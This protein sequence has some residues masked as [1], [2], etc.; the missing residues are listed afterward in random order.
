MLDRDDASLR[1]AAEDFGHLVHHLPRAVLRPSTIAEVA[2]IVASASEARL[3]VAARGAGHSSYGQAQCAGGIVIDMS[4]L[5]LVSEP[6]VD[7][8][9]VQGG[10]LWSS[11]LEATLAGGTTPAV[12]TDYLHTSVGGT[13]AAGGV[14]GTSH[15]Y[16]FQVD[17]VEE[18]RVVTGT[19]R[20]VTCSPRRN[21]EL[22]DAIRAGLGQCGITVSATLRV[23]PAPALV[24][25]YRL[26]Y[27]DLATF[28]ADQRDLVLQGR[29]DFLQGQI[30]LVAGGWRYLVEAAAYHPPLAVPTGAALPDGLHDDR[31]A[32]EID[33]LPYR[34]FAHR[35]AT[36][37][38]ALRASG[39]WLHPHPWLTTFLPAQDAAALAGEVLASR[40]L[41][42][43][44]NSGLV[45]TY[46]LRADR[47]CAPLTRVPD[48]ELVWLFGLLRTASPED[49]AGVTAQ[50]EA[51]R[52]IR[53]RVLA[54]GGT[55]Y[56]INAVPMSPRDWR[57]HFG[58][59]WEQLR[60]AKEKF[61]PR[62]ILTPGCGISA[63]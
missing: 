36:G 18:L 54:R 10:A 2:D 55:A 49:P 20:P 3:S 1:W 12:L 31:A 4:G 33:D 37:E 43:L 29:F 38:A 44:G 58:P 40:A 60:A 19:G 13:L 6:Q 11:V 46:P 27:H 32:R 59:R 56:P 15:R 9:T 47:L 42:Q 23:I 39:E 48:S 41:C 17:T 5:N 51:N 45:L 22:F 50:I 24:R 35:M 25:R 8:I 57:T 62:G 34:E 21:R 63:G 61:D 30:V 53:D 52:L 16:G 26:H 28:L 14:G 7:R